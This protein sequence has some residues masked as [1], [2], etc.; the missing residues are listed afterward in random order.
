MIT[1]RK[2]LWADIGRKAQKIS[3]ETKTYKDVFEALQDAYVCMVHM[4]SNLELS[5][6]TCDKAP[7][8]IATFY[9]LSGS[10]LDV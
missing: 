1:I 8:E 9:G 2:T 10:L 4:P 5:L 7:K 3:A 6:E